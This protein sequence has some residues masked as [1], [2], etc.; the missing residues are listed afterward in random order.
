M[1]DI[2]R[3]ETTGI[4]KIID[5]YS[6]SATGSFAAPPFEE[7]DDDYTF[8]FSNL[9]DVERFS[10]FTY[11]YGID[12]YGGY[13]QSED[14]SGKR[15]LYPEY[16]VSRDYTNWTQWLELKSNID[17]FPP[18]TSKDTMYLNIRFTRKGTIGS[19]V[20]RL[21]SY[22]L[23]GNI[24]I[25]I[26]DGE[27]TA[28]L[29]PLNSTLVIKPPFI[30]KVFKITD[31]EVLSSGDIDAVSIKYRFSQD[32]GR[33]VT[34]WE[35]FTKENITT[36]RITPIRFFQIEYL[37]ELDTDIYPP[38]STGSTVKIYDI[39]LI[40]DFQNVSLDYLKTNLY[41][42]REN[43]NC[44]KLGMVDTPV[45]A[46]LISDSL[47][48][49]EVSILPQLSSEQLSALFNP[50][51][52][53]QA[54]ELLNKISNDAN[55]MFGHEVV[56][57][58][59]D[60]DKKG[61][62]YTFHEYQ[63]YNYVCDELLK[64]SVEGNQFPENSGAINQFDLSLF[65]SFEVHIPKEVF[66][67][68]F[69]PEKRPSKEDFLWFC[70][71]N[72]MFTVEHSQ[73][74]R[75]FNNQA[76]YY[77]VMLKKYTQKANV[78]A[79]VGNQTIQERV[80]E[81][82]KNSTI[83]ELFGIENTQDKM[84]VANKE[85]FRSLTHDILRVD[86]IAKIERELIENAELVIAKYHYDLS[87]VA[88][89]PSQSYDAVIYRNINNY[90]D[91]SNNIGFMCWFNI[92]NYVV[93]EKYNFFNYFDTTNNY[94]ININILADSI[95]VSLNS[96]TYSIPLGVTG[97]ADGLDESTWYSYVLNVDQRQR[98]ISQFVY[99]RDVD[100]E[101]QAGN[102]NT[103]KL[104]LLYNLEATMEPVEIIL[105]NIDAK[106]LSSDMKITNLRLFS[107]IIPIDQHNKILNQAIISDD[108]KYLIFAD[109]ANKK[110]SLPHMIQSQV[111]KNDVG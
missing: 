22:T 33:T 36:V 109:N 34:N 88:F 65:D 84:A 15:Y 54:V 67:K 93:N 14:I 70:E 108:S 29:N 45:E 42:V 69:G 97:S 5:S 27:S 9:S 96:S 101:S 7:I 44:L 82:T 110:L 75:G 92:N 39:N 57:F 8:I 107:D 64:I 99:K 81:L 6:F 76:I 3:N 94:G 78:I 41:G 60:P 58:L 79:G 85:Q 71:L 86:I 59:T 61:T 48:S 74:F 49:S 20:I 52:L 12:P 50:Y 17:N 13:S 10:S 111:G 26:I 43:C 23:T 51:Q 30:Y 37:L 2:I 35:P 40:G 11:S 90:F 83:D 100:D 66:K 89:G 98:K 102:I 68:S 91:V 55:S 63:L 73:P 47:T 87:S 18:F 105:N 21:L 28:L 103:T 1:Y 95:D 104:R 77:K 80:R 25:N 46:E 32:Y 62:D 24:S 4:I 53:T 19:G 31:I 56:Y 106:I 16:R 38:G 72:R